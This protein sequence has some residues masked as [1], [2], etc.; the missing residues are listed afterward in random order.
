MEGR[1]IFEVIQREQCPALAPGIPHQWTTLQVGP[2]YRLKQCE[3]C[4]LQAE[5]DTSG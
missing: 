5:S 3:G 2:Q 4:G 1:A